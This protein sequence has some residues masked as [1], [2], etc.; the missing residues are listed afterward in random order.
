METDAI[1]PAAMYA[2]LLAAY[3]PQHWWPGQTAFEVIVG[4]VLTQNTAWANVERAIANLRAE[5]L[6]ELDSLWRA[7]PDRV[8]ALI[9]PSGFYNVKYRRLRAL[10]DYLHADGYWERLG[11][12]PVDALRAE[13]GAVPGIGPETC[14]S[15][16]LYAFQ[17]PVMVV[18][19]YTRRLLARLGHAWAMRAPYDEVQR[20]LTADVPCG[21]ALYNELHAQIVVH[22]KRRCR[23]H[24]LCAMCPLGD[25]C[26][27][28]ITLFSQPPAAENV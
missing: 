3:G 17:R 2:R 18:D 23:P 25:V 20:F 24:P 5:G 14:D 1:R 12:A 28:R 9:R 4:A 19:A 16:L 15:I 10:L 7:D 21:A 6:L 11:S 22:G 8:R 26:S 13:L 27:A